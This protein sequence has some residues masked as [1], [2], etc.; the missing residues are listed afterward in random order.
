MFILVY[1][2]YK[3]EKVQVRYQSQCSQSSDYDKGRLDICGHTGIQF[4][5]GIWHRVSDWV[6]V[7]VFFL[8][9]KNL[10]STY[11]FRADTS[12]QMGSSDPIRIEREKF[13]RST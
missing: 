6:L 5:H 2:K 1:S 8:A 12:A 10:T 4:S 11:R 7:G 13:K 9:Q 3:N